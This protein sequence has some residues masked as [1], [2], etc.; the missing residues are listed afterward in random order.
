MRH[1]QLAALVEVAAERLFAQLDGDGDTS[2][3]V[4]GAV[5]EGADTGPELETVV[6]VAHDRVNRL[7]RL[8]LISWT[9][10]RYLHDLLVYRGD[11]FWAR[12]GNLVISNQGDPTH[13]IQGAEYTAMLNPD[14]VPTLLDVEPQGESSVAGRRSIR[15]AASTHMPRRPS[16]LEMDLFGM[17]PGGET[18]TLDVDYATGILLRVVKVVDDQEAEVR[19][20]LELSLGGP[21]ADALFCR[22]QMILD[23]GRARS[24]QCSS[25]RRGTSIR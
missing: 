25:D 12:T 23:W 1:W 13:E 17:V 15:V 19:E 21:L 10:D 4:T 22:P 9:G 20:W 8:S 24:E 18:F 6:G 11:T 16:L 2:H 5:K 3:Q 14:A 7:Q